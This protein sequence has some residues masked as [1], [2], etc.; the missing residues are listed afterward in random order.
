MERNTPPENLD[1]PKPWEDREITRAQ[2]EHHRE[3]L[4]RNAIGW[5]PDGWW[6]YEK[7]M[8]VP[9]V[10]WQQTKIL[11]SMGE[12]KGAEL[13]SVMSLWRDKYDAACDM[14]GPREKHDDW[15]DIPRSIIKQC[16]VEA[17]SV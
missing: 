9:G 5:R 8:K 13:Q 12:L 2:W 17:Q 4:M 6:L 14:G 11:Y 15:A 3:L 1:L 16:D 10:P 7:N